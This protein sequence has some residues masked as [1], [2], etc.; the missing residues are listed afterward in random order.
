MLYRRDS[1]KALA[2]PPGFAARAADVPWPT[3]IA[4]AEAGEA[5][6][7]LVHAPVGELLDAALI[8]APDRPVA[9]ELALRLATLAIRDALITIVP[10][11]TSV[12]VAAAGS[13][14]IDRGEVAT[15]R[16]ARGPA[17]EDGVP[18]WLVLGFTVRL[19]LRLEAPGLTPW[20][21]DLAEEGVEVSGDA[22]LELICRHLLAQIDAWHE[23][24][25][26]GIARAWRNAGALQP[27]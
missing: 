16:L 13:V 22:L 8:L 11:E 26:P 3:A 15:A 5:P 18:S 17:L 21:T 9:D 4:E 12:T 10:P 2:L 23:E 7:T 6:G 25:E 24:G 14:A 1:H 27:A 19:A 20:L